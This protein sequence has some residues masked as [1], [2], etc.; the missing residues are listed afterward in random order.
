MTSVFEAVGGAVRGIACALLGADEFIAG[1]AGRFSPG[2]GELLYD[3]IAA[4]RRL[5][6]CDPDDDPDLPAPP[7]TG[8]QCSAR[9][10]VTVFR[11]FAAGSSGGVCTGESSFSS[12]ING[13]WGPIGGI[14]FGG[15]GTCTNRESN[16]DIFLSCRGNDTSP[17]PGPVNVLV[18][19]GNTFFSAVITNIVR[20]GGLP[21]DC[22]DPGPVYPPPT[23]FNFNT[24]ITYNIDDGT[25][26]TVNVPFVF[27][28]IITNFD[29]TLRIPFNFDLGGVE[30]SGNLNLQPNLNVTINPPSFPPGTNQDSD[31]LPPGDPGDEVEP[32]PPDQKIIGV[33]AVSEIIGE[34]QFTTILTDGMPNILAPRAGSIKFAYSVGISTFWSND[35]DVKGGRVFIPCPFSQGA[36]AVVVSAASGVTVTF[37]EIRGFPLA[38]VDDVARAGG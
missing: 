29:G 33:V 25:E 14:V 12:T 7:F 11:T 4:G 28:P 20:Q 30:F 23:N 19:A 36:D 15:A 34:Q 32:A 10:N 22:G 13:I 31:D 16:Q 2:L 17:T 27:A 18:S 38:T 6:G 5:Y 9:Y 37:R 3:R 26:V 8:G 1:S 24:D 21:D 35:I